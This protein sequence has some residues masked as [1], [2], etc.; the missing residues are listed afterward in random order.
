MGFVALM[1]AAFMLIAYRSEVARFY[2]ALDW[3]LLFF[4]IGLFVVINVMEHG[5]VLHEIG[6]WISALIGEGGRM[7]ASSLL[8][9]SAAASSVTDNI[10]LS[11]MLAKILAARESG[12]DD[13]LWWAVVFGSN[14]G[15]NLT[16]IGSAS[17]VVAVTVI[18]KYKIKL[19]FF[20][21][22]VAALPFAIVQIALAVLYVVLRY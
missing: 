10:P 1:F 4:F 3:D 14:L 20:K 17:T 16:P 15:G 7:G 12:V 9:A 13:G 18:H 22:V 11:A 5:G 6:R 21:F 8:V 2:S 19:S